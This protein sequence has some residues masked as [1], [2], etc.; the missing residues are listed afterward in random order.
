MTTPRERRLQAD[1]QKVQGLVAGS[2]GGLKLISTQGQPPT[3]Y[4]IEYHCPSLVKEAG[5]AAIVRRQH[6]VEIR[7][8]STYPLRTG[9]ATARLLTPVF[10]PHVFFNQDICLGARWNPTE[11]LDTLV[12]KIGA[13]LQ[14]D[15]RVLDFNSLANPEAGAWVKKHPGQTPLPGAVD[16]K[17]P[18]NEHG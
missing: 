11:T 8:D 17:A 6:R 5:A 2:G 4:V 18:R 15:P 1:F 3:T 13:I 7:L 14:L 9:S 10:N 16:F 12:L